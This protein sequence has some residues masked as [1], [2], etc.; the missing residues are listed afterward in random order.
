MQ[1]NRANMASLRS[2]AL[3]GAT[4]HLGSE[5]AKALLSPKYRSSYGSVI[6]LT[7]QQPS[8]SKAVP[9]V[10]LRS[11]TN[12]TLSQAL[13]GIDV[14]ISTVGPTGH[15]FKDSLVDA[16]AGS[17]VKLYIPSEFGV[18]HTVNDFSQPEWDR[19]TKHDNKVKASLHQTKVCRIYSG[20]FL[21]DSIGPWFGLD[22]KNCVF[23]AIGSAD[24]PISFTALG[25]VGNLVAQVARMPYEEIP[26]HMHISSDTMTIR[27]IAKAMEVAGAPLISITEVDLKAF[28]Q[29]ALNE[30]SDD[31]SKYLRFLMGERKIDH[32]VSGLGND[33]ELVN[34][35][36]QIWHW[37]TVAQYA[38]E[39]KGQPWI[40]LDWPPHGSN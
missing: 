27:Q 31:P 25:D 1:T 37:R 13:N 35:R 3:V 8:S 33:N 5:V 2:I 12:D 39:V 17:N 38:K 21:E 22:I 6:F 26:E 19:K 29:Q 10:E 15:E 24:Q 14:L 30:N 28:K 32:T 23:E 7:R 9:G 4:G 20:L 11:F 16:M 18:D 40:D 34:P 36:Q